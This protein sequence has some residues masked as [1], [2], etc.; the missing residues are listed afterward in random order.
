MTLLQLIS[1]NEWKLIIIG[2]GIYLTCNLIK[3]IRR[4]NKIQEDLIKT[5][6]DIKKLKFYHKKFSEAKT[7]EDFR[8]VEEW[9]KKNSNAFYY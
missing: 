3:E 4:S 2:I 6:E 7:K 9:R 8:K 1:P 5:N